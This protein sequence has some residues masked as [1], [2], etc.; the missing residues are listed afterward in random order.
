MKLSVKFIIDTSMYTFNTNDTVL[1]SKIQYTV[2]TLHP[3][4][5]GRSKLL[6]EDFFLPFYHICG[7]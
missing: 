2:D 1:T 5:L 6:K 7:S 3:L 4:W